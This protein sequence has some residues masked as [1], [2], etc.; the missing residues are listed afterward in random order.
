MVSHFWL[1][2][3]FMISSGFEENSHVTSSDRICVFFSIH[4]GVSSGATISA[5]KIAVTYT[6]A[7]LATSRH[8]SNQWLPVFSYMKKKIAQMLL[9][10]WSIPENV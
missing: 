3:S 9:N 7:S 6:S 5:H 4:C 8:N 10:A 2:K 1:P